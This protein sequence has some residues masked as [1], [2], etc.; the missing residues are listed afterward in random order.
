MEHLNHHV[1]AFFVVM[2]DCN[3]GHDE[4]EEFHFWDDLYQSEIQAQ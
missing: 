3:T 1:L 2:A 4:F